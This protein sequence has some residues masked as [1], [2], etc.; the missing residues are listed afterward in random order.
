MWQQH[1]GKFEFNEEALMFILDQLYAGRF[2]TFVCTTD[3]A[4]RKHKLAQ[5]TP[6]LWHF[7]LQNER[8][9][10][11]QFYTAPAEPKAV[12]EDGPPPKPEPLDIAAGQVCLWGGYYLRYMNEAGEE[13]L[14]SA[15]QEAG[16]TTSALA[17]PSSKLTVLPV[18]ML[19]QIEH[20]TLVTS[21]DLS[22]NLLTA[23][24]LACTRFSAVTKLL[25][26]SNQLNPS[27]AFFEL[28]SRHTPQLAE[29]DLS[30]NCITKWCVALA[31]PTS[32]R[33]LRLANNRL[34]DVAAV[35]SSFTALHTLVLSDNAITS[36]TEHLPRSLTHL[37]VLP[38]W[39]PANTTL[40]S[41]QQRTTQTY[42]TY[43]DS[44]DLAQM[45]RTTR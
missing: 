27:R 31:T 29:L 35:V 8:H 36:L 44:A 34:T 30:A 45:W 5:K 20:P 2:G 4:R 18:H 16:L 13:A 42:N 24:P 41:Q 43:P 3:K 32:L 39:T 14:A 23:V 26:A 38:T 37:G 11:N 9:F 7:M 40:H 1:P 21:V 10:R 33:V 22:A 15:V 19:E 6:S 28:L 17:L 12:E 25:L